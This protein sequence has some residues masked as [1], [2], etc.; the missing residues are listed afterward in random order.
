MKFGIIALLGIFVSIQSQASQGGMVQVGPQQAVQFID[1]KDDRYEPVYGEVPYQDTCSREVFDH[2]ENRCH[3]EMDSVCN[4]GGEV[5]TTENDSVCNSR[6]CTSVPRRVCHQAPRSCTSVPRNVCQ[7]YAVS[8]TVYYSCTRYRTEVV[9][10]RLAKSY[11]HRIEVRLD[12]PSDFDSRML[13]VALQI[14]EESVSA[15]LRSSYPG[16]LLNYRVDV[17][18]RSDANDV[19]SLS[20]RV[21]ISKG[22]SSEQARTILNGAISGL[23]LGHNA[24]RF[25]IENEAQ[26]LD[27]LKIRVK[28]VRNPKLWAST[29]LFDG[30]LRASALGLVGQGQNINAV[31]PVEKMGVD[32]IG[33]KRYDV[34]VSVS[35]DP[36][37][38]LNTGDFQ[39]E[40][41]KR[42]EQSREKIYATF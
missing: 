19:V 12:S 13:D 10:Q 29:T 16:A 36:G 28:L 38:V 5:C 18:N 7:Q 40:L 15:N 26:I 30:D 6:G 11:Q 32:E 37:K 27:S 41:G 8:R 1:L 14:N 17:V 34:S 20:E 9:G 24:I 2:Y 42:L 23:E 25:Q 39:G 35:L 3:T 4:G 31:I 21:V 22:L 33:S